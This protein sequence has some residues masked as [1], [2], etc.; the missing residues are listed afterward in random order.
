MIPVSQ[1]FL[2][3]RPHGP[4]MACPRRKRPNIQ[5]ERTKFSMK[6]EERFTAYREENKMVLVL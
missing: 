4:I 2:R 3:P 1:I 5:T 6:T